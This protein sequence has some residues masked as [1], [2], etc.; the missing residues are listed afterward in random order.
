MAVSPLHGLLETMHTA[1]G[2]PCLVGKASHTLRAVVTKTLE[3]EKTSVPKSHVGL[4]LQR[5]AELSPEFSSSEYL[6]DTQL[7]RLKR[8]PDLGAGQMRLLGMHV[9]LQLVKLAFAH[10]QIVPEVQYDGATV[11][12]HPMQPG[13]D[14]ILV[15][16]D[17]SRGR[18]QRIAFRSACTAVSKIAGSAYRPSYAVP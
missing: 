13:A 16:L 18:A 10:M 17:D 11:A 8:I 5:V 7:S 6:T 15:H 3:N 12:R 4:V 1:F 2:K 14:G 9:T